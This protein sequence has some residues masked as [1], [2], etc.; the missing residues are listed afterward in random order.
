MKE[1]LWTSPKCLTSAGKGFKNQN[2]IQIE[3]KGHM[4]TGGTRLSSEKN[5]HVV[6]ERL[7]AKR[8]EMCLDVSLV[9]GAPP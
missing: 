8:K 2:S 6:L 9:E 1:E 4:N 5:G 3:G 7:K